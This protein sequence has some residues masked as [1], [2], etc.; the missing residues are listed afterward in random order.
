MF[1][2]GMSAKRF[3]AEQRV[4]GTFS[5]NLTLCEELRSKWFEA[6]PECVK[7]LECDQ[8]STD[9]ESGK[10]L[11]MSK[12]LT[13]RI[14][15]NCSRNEAAN[16]KFQGLSADGGKRAV[17]RLYRENFHIINYIHDEF[18]FLMKEDDQLTENVRRAEEIMIAEM[19][20]VIPDVVIKVESALMRRWNKKAKS[21]MENGKLTI[22]EE[23]A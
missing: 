3:L 19:R 5:L 15:G 13:G 14:R 10:P 20:V 6:Y 1:P 7:H 9:E 23:T 16:S 8:C 12:T 11:F 22:W 4:F 17:W 18:I 2:G 21:K